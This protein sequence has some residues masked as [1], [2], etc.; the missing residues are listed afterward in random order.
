MENPYDEVIDMLNEYR[1][2]AMKINISWYRKAMFIYVDY[3]EDMVGANNYDD[4]ILFH[5]FMC[6]RNGKNYQRQVTLDLYMENYQLAMKGY[7]ELT[8]KVVN[9]EDDDMYVDFVNYYNKFWDKNQLTKPPVKTDK[10][11]KDIENIWNLSSSGEFPNSKTI[12]RHEITVYED[13]NSS[14]NE[15]HSPSADIISV[16]SSLSEHSSSQE[17]YHIDDVYVDSWDDHNDDNLENIPLDD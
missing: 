3:L 8:G 6:M 10:T 1:K 12:D 15:R 7:T 14:H 13:Y 4:I 11:F 16:H 17:Q 2:Y 5:E 9:I